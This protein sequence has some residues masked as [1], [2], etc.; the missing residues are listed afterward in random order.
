MEAKREKKKERKNKNRCKKTKMPE[1][2][3]TEEKK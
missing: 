1:L 3:K 2:I